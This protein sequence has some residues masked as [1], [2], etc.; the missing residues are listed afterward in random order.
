MIFRPRVTFP[1]VDVQPVELF[2]L[3]EI[4]IE[5]GSCL[6]LPITRTK[7]CLTAVQFNGESRK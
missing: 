6:H 5:D 4:Q 7:C 3:R 2:Q 1:D